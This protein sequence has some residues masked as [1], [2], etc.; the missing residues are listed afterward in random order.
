VIDGS[1]PQ[2][3]RK[4]DALLSAGLFSLPGSDRSLALRN[5]LRGVALS[6][7]SGQDVARALG[8]PPLSGA[9]LGTDLDPTPLWFYILKE[10]ELAG[11]TQLGAV[12]GR[13][14]AEVLVG[15]LELDP[16]SWINQEPTW[17]PTIPAATEGQLT[18][19]D[20]LRFAAS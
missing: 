13:I 5:L 20:L 15:L 14:V 12:G 1:D 8:L 10:S 3:S 2:P 11:A 19:G 4:I 6:L 7:P 17:R 16:R 18:V 9:E